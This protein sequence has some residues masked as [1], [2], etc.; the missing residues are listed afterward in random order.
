MC[1]NH[2]HEHDHGAGHS[3]DDGAGHDHSHGHADEPTPEDD[4]VR[5]AVVGKGG[6]G[7]STL[8]AAIATELATEHEVLAVDADPDANL[9]RA[10]GC[11]NPPAITDER[12]LIEDRV[13]ERGGLLTL[14]P[15][16]EDVFESHSST[17]GGAGRLL[18]IGAPK[19]GNTGCLC[20]EN[21]FVQSLVRSALETDRVVM[22]MEAGIEHLGRG[23]ADA[24]DAMV[25]VVEPSVAS[26]E[27]ADRIETLASDLAIPTY[28][29]VNKVRGDPSAVTDRLAQPVLG[30]LEYDEHVADA[31]LRGDP[32][33]EASPAL[34]AIARDVIA[35]LE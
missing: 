23:T 15:D 35:E 16:V 25:V 18:T 4:A 33:V 1:D 17:F 24:V 5:L 27:T 14:T 31:A 13:G 11:E 8:S 6:V 26:L 32:V 2:D 22:D 3:H 30:T 28:A 7:K 29:V 12:D 20:P 10:L 21:S 19:G 9:A 34:R